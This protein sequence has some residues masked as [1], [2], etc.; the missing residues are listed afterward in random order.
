MP[1]AIKP[2]TK[3]ITELSAIYDRIYDIADRLIKKHNPCNI[4]TKIVPAKKL[5]FNPIF[6]EQLIENTYCNSNGTVNALCCEGC[7]YWDK[8]CTV[9]ALGCK[10]FLCQCVKNK[11]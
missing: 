11:N 9:K 7:K 3:S 2:T 1:T 8:G 10:L 4:Y 6:P 5:F